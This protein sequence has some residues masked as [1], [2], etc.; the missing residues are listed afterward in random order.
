MFFQT[1]NLPNAPQRTGWLRTLSVVT[2]N[3]SDEPGATQKTIVK[4]KKITK[5]VCRLGAQLCEAAL[6]TGAWGPN[7]AAGSGA[8]GRTAV[9]G[10]QLAPAP[11][12]RRPAPQLESTGPWKDDTAC[13]DPQCWTALASR[14]P[15][16]TICPSP[17]YSAA[18]VQCAWP[19]PSIFLGPPSVLTTASEG[20]VLRLSEDTQVPRTWL[21][22][23]PAPGLQAP[24]PT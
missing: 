2:G 6:P 9:R 21:C 16:H 12:G 18:G 1:F 8:A 15:R 24:G 4:K 17:P 22:A 5:T 3:N 20:R 23:G 19:A 14:G 10:A 11:W 13:Q 7:S